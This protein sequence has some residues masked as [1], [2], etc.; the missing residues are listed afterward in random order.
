MSLVAQSRRQVLIPLRVTRLFVRRQLRGRR[1]Q[2]TGLNP[3][4]GHPPLRTDGWDGWPEADA[5][6][7]IPLRVTRLFVHA[8]HLADDAEQ[9]V[10]I[11]LRVT[12]LFVL[13]SFSGRSLGNLLS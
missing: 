11:P 12:R 9:K 2:G 1:R 13:E 4:Q 8:A 6:V 10:L 5:T 3:S 7:L